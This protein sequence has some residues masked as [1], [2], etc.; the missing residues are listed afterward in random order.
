LCCRRRPDDCYDVWVE[1]DEL[2]DPKFRHTDQGFVF[3]PEVP[4]RTYRDLRRSDYPTVQEQLDALWHAMDQ[5]LLPK[6]EP[7]YSQVRAVKQRHPKP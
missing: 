2:M 5:G 6:V 3:D 4:A 7:M 1:G